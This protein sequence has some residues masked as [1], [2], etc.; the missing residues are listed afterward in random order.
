ML[1]K[2]LPQAAQLPWTSDYFIKQ[3]VSF[4]EKN[5]STQAA[6]PPQTSDFFKEVGFLEKVLPQT[7]GSAARKRTTTAAKGAERLLG[8]LEGGATPPP[9]AKFK[10][11][12]WPLC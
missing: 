2:V 3:S 6:Q 11:P 7:S 12:M 9:A 8:G 4:F 1:E 5:T 10:P